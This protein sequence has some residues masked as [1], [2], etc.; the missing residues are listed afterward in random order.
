[1]HIWQLLSPYC[2]HFIHDFER[3]LSKRYEIHKSNVPLNEIKCLLISVYLFSIICLHQV[4]VNVFHCLYIV[5]LSWCHFYKNFLQFSL[6]FSRLNFK[7]LDMCKNYYY[8]KKHLPSR[9]PLKMLIDDECIA[10]E[11]NDV[12][13]V[14]F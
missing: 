8:R 1:M 3:K 13:S 14:D 4:T 9:R 5:F 12:K 10:T 2:L 7:W 6:L 11:D